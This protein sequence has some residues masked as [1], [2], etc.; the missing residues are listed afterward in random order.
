MLSGMSFN[1]SSVIYS[2]NDRPLPPP[3]NSIHYEESPFGVTKSNFRTT[4]RGFSANRPK[5]GSRNQAQKEPFKDPDVWESPPPMEK[6]QSVQKVNKI[7]SNSN[8]NHQIRSVPA[9]KK[10]D[11]NG[12]KKT[13]L[14]DR[15]PNGSGPDS[16]L[17]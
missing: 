5:P 1:N 6:R 2:R 13:F 15:Y 10:A 16:N 9:K 17:I 4:N 12:E 3:N 11:G 7:N 8:R 14:N